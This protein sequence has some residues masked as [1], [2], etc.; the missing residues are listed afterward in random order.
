MC[1][2]EFYQN[3][4]W[5]EEKLRVPSGRLLLSILLGIYMNDLWFVWT[6]A[7]YEAYIHDLSRSSLARRAHPR[8][9]QLRF[10]LT[11]S[12]LIRC[13]LVFQISVTFSEVFLRNTAKLTLGYP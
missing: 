11:A 12:E 8:S 2:E 7:Q 9:V 5:K 6:E 10:K 4:S 1:S 13:R 3:L